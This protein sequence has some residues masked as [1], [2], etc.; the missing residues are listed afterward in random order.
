MS[1]S[2]NID[3]SGKE[4]RYNAYIRTGLKFIVKSKFK[5]A[6]KEFLKA[7]KL[8]NEIPVAYNNLGSAFILLAEYTEAITHLSKALA[9][10]QEGIKPKKDDIFAFLATAEKPEMKGFS[11]SPRSKNTSDFLLNYKDKVHRPLISQQQQEA[12]IIHN[13][14]GLAYYKLEEHDKAISHFEEVLNLD[15]NNALACCT[16]YSIYSQHAIKDKANHYRN[17]TIDLSLKNA[18]ENLQFGAVKA[19]LGDF[20]TAISYCKEAIFYYELTLELEP[21]IKGPSLGYEDLDPF[22]RSLDGN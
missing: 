14:L 22:F 20:V 15:S 13:N 21:K 7:L 6:T 8:D 10:Y 18:D 9:I 4:S 11:F 3:D 16:L 12:A 19:K 2:T 17:K 5:A 1:R